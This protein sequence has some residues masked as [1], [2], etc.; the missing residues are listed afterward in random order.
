MLQRRNGSGSRRATLP[1]S[2]RQ[3][4]YSRSEEAPTLRQTSR[5]RT[6]ED[7]EERDEES[8]RRAESL[9]D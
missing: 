6:H 1:S 3:A 9:A 2:G 5:F 7:D 4:D 8:N